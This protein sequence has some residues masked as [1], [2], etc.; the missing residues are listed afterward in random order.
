M[1]Q[2]NLLTIWR[3]FNRFRSVF[4]INLVGLSSG[5]ACVLL[6]YLWV[7]DE[8][9]VDKFHE[10]D[11]R[12]FQVMVNEQR[13]GSVKTTGQTPLFAGAAMA[14]ELPEIEYAVVT[15][16]P[17]FF[18]AF[19]LSQ[20]GTQ[21]RGTGKYAG[22]DFFNI[23]SYDL[24]DGDKDHVLADKHSVVLSET[25]A[26]K[27]FGTTENLSGKVLEY[28]I[29]D[30][31]K[32]VAVSGIFRDVPA[33][34]SEHFDMVFPF[35]AFEDMM[36]MTQAP[37]N[38]DAPAPFYLYIALKGDAIDEAVNS[39]LANFIKRKSNTSP[40]TLFLV[41]YSDQYLYGR[42]DNGIPAGGRI[43]YIQLVSVIALFILVIACV[44]FMNLFTAKAS[45]RIKAVGIKKAVG[46]SR[47]TLVVQYL[48]EALLMS[49][50]S[51]V[52]AIL[53]TDLLLPA[54]NNVTGKSIALT[55]DF[56]TIAAM[57]TITLATGIM[58]GLYPSLH[59]SGYN[60]VAGLKGKITDATHE[61]WVRKGLVIFQFAISV[62]LIA[63][64]LVVHR[65]VEYVLQKD[66]GYNKEN[67]LYFEAD[68]K[69]AENPEAFLAEVRKIPGVASASS[70]L[71]DLTGRGNGLPGS[72][73]WEG[74]QVVI[75]SAAV[76]Y[77]MLETLGVRLKQGRFFS[78]LL[79]HG[80]DTLKCILNEAA[81]ETLSLE[82]PV[83]KKVGG[84]EVIGVVG[85]FHFQSL[86]ES[87]KPFSFRL[88][89]HYALGIWLRIDPG[90]TAST[91]ERIR[92]CYQRFNPGLPLDFTFL[93]QAYQAQYAAEQKVRTL[94]QYFAA[95]A[96]IISC[97]G[98]FGL[99]AFTTDRRK[100]EIG[101]RKVMGSSTAGIVTLL[102]GDF[103]RL[104]I[105]AMVIAFPVA[106][107]ISAQW[108]G[109]F[110]YK[111]T[112]QWW[113]FAGA[114]IIALLIAGM[115]VGAQAIRAARANPT[116]CLKEE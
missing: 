45:A 12:L 13:N 63:S 61:V 88:E 110:A 2:H 111:I 98:L 52:I 9:S 22:K 33:N 72:I 14:D 66:L 1:F 20:E 43:E 69:V 92:H 47:K 83:G 87:V 79:D 73:L 5:L 46:A 48:A 86:H 36:G 56:E 29:F 15:T 24:I 103:I 51:L 8:M 95:L 97:L 3:S 67:L 23:F 65:Q 40:F 75:H 11:K 68:G 71:G 18:P 60:A 78:D 38:W 101:I 113:Y 112:M 42:Y 99:A 91:L 114:G 59:L 76:N 37:V 6:I 57:V 108:L 34:A 53:V 25:M 84:L 93:D 100:K 30:I 82:D 64:V 107:F 27:L 4:V 16:P 109:S 105:A 50:V 21:A 116:Q 41:R 32:Q 81:V 102:S 28:R 58:A 62:V 39:K 74:R 44:N 10:H 77:N 7:K 85:D 49:A 19:T 94:S 90:T 54:F 96:I 26:R 89:P 80:D 31:K 70:M 115:T 17:A 104:V 35:E 55:F 106:Y